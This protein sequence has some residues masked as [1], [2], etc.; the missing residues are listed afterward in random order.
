ML[1]LSP[2]VWA[3]RGGVVAALVTLLAPVALAAPSVAGSTVASSALNSGAVRTWN[4]HAVNALI[5]APT[6]AVPGAGQSPP[7]S[8]L[9]L[10]IVHT[11]IFDPVNAIA[12]GYEPYLTGLPPASPSASQDAA[13]AA[14]AH[15][16]LVGLGRGLVPPLPQDVRDRLDALYTDALADIPD[17]QAKTDGIAI[18]AAA[19]SGVRRCRRTST[20][21]SRGWRGSSRSCSTTPRSFE[22]RDRRR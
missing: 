8:E 13:V 10:A 14:A 7:V 2:V 17:G 4:L 1:R 21:R 9:H 11:A 20:T 19:V 3:R 15:D 5:N 16:V 12:G 6:A 18:R 22:R